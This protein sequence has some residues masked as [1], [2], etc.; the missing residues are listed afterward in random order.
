V[1][2]SLELASQESIVIQELMKED[3]GPD[4][5]NLAYFSLGLAALVWKTP[6]KVNNVYIRGRV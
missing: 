5:G 1:R 4:S 6:Q 3:F 2:V